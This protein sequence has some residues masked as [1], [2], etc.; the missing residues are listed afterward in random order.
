MDSTRSADVTR[1]TRLSE[2]GSRD[3]GALDALLDQAQ[4]GH[5]GVVRDGLP[6]V[7]PTAVAR[8]GDRLLMHGST[9]SGWMREAAAGAPVCVTVTVIE[10]LVVARSAFESSMLY[11]S[12][13]LFGRCTSLDAAEKRQALDLFT[14]HLLPGRV[15]EVREPTTKELAATLV[16]ALP[17]ERWSL[18]ISD[19]WPEDPEADVVGPAWA[20]VVRSRTR[21]GVPEP[22]PDLRA[23]IEVPASVRSLSVT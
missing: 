14:E 4:V 5:V 17:I 2:L 3:R 19:G 1:I 15:A 6:V 10:G 21:F 22:A 7:V 12:A 9:G 23:G 11:R 18:K 20:G 8:D 13:A 16:L